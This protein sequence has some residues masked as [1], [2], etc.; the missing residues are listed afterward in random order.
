MRG[1]CGRMAG[2]TC[3]L[4]LV[5]SLLGQRATAQ[6][7]VVDAQ[8]RAGTAA[9]RITQDACQKAI[10]IFQFT[11]PQLA[12]TLAGGNAVAG[13]HSS[14]R[15][16][17]HFSIG[18]RA[19]ALE[20]S[21]PRVDQRT[22]ATTGAVAS[23]YAIDK[24][25]IAVPVVDAAIGLFRGIPALGTYALGLDALVHVAYIP[26]ID[27]N[28]LAIEVPDGSFK[29]GLGG[30]VGILA[31][32]FMTP[33]I[34]FTWLQRDLP[35][36]NLLGRVAGDDLHVRDARVRTTAWRIVAGKNLT[37]FGVAVGGGR[38]RYETSA[39]AQVT[40]NRVVP[41]VTSS[42]VTSSQ[43]LDRTNVFANVSLNLPALRVVGEVG[44]VSGGTVVTYNSF[45]DAR[46]HDPRT[47]ASLG[48]RLAW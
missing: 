14:L 15:G 6:A 41:A 3:C 36:V 10:D 46:G 13:E 20:S 26:S 24:Q 48:L 33:G 45:G 43:A 29:F 12:A 38:D 9:E 8:C 27:E 4:A 37:L 23:T 25:W 5:A 35:T 47:Y 31:E 7:P 17:G 39:N 22:P 1:W 30:R 32:T 18:L 16:P 11:A 42:V 28:D 2:R 21:L 19:T 34:S 40:I 44:R